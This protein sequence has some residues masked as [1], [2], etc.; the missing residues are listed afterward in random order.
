MTWLV[1][2]K[3]E[4]LSEKQMR[5]IQIAMMDFSYDSHQNSIT[6]HH[7][8]NGNSRIVKPNPK[9]IITYVENTDRDGDDV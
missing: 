6:Y 8:P 2:K 5:Q 3:V 4:Y 9:T 7:Y 1:N